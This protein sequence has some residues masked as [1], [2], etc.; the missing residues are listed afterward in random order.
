MYT[1]FPSLHQ[2]PPLLEHDVDP[3]VL[4]VIHHIATMTIFLCF[5]VAKPELSQQTVAFPMESPEQPAF[6]AAVVRSFYTWL[7]EAVAPR[8]HDRPIRSASMNAFN[9][10]MKSV[11]SLF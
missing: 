4:S 8:Q 6:S 7:T 2:P 10:E 9:I 1:V 3:A 11:G 5:F